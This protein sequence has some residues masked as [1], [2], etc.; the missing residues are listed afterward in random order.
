VDGLNRLNLLEYAKISSRTEDYG[1]QPHLA[2]KGLWSF[3]V[4]TGFSQCYKSPRESSF[5]E[6]DTI[7]TYRP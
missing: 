3:R 6:F 2:P 1:E 4:N 5:V 7:H